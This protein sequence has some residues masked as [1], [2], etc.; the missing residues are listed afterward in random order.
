MDY[1]RNLLW[2]KQNQL[3]PTKK[4]YIFY[5]SRK[6][7]LYLYFFADGTNDCFSK[8]GYLSNE[9]INSKQL[10]QYRAQPVY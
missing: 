4:Q 9:C 8:G 2:K 7:S 10:E 1:T 5:S 6:D 3:S